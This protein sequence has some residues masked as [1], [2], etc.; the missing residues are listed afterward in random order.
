MVKNGVVLG[1]DLEGHSTKNAGDD[2]GRA[3]CAAISS[4][5]YMTANTITDVIGD[6]ADVKVSEGAMSLRVKT[7]SPETEAV[8]KGLKLHLSELQKLYGKR[9]IITEV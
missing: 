3:L 8:L 5:A 4:A 1:F 2:E 7:P 6:E 9:L